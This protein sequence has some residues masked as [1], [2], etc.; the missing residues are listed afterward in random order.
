VYLSLHA[1]V[2]T[3]I[4]VAVV[5]LCQD[6]RLYELYNVSLRYRFHAIGRAG[7]G[8]LSVLSTAQ[9]ATY[10][11]IKVIGFSLVINDDSETD[12]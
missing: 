9:S 11:N 7:K 12:V 8:V 6:N 3:D 4:M 1:S 10:H 2:G 5:S